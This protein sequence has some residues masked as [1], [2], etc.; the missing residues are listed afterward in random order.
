MFKRFRDRRVSPEIR[1]QNRET[2]L[3]TKDFIYPVFLLE[4]KEREE[5]IPS[6]PGVSRRSLDRLL[7]YLEWPVKLG[8]RSILVFA[9]PDHKGVEQA[10]RSDGLM[11]RSLP[12]IKSHFPQLEVITDV[13]ICSF[14]ENGQ[15]H[16]GDN[17]QTIEILAKIALS[18]LQSGADIVAP[19]DMMDGRVW[20]IHRLLTH[21][22]IK[23]PQI[24]SYAAKYASSFYGPFR[25][26]ADCAPKTGD[27]KSY[28]MDPANSNEAM[29]EIQADLEEG[30]TSIIIKPALSYLDIIFRASKRFDCPI[31][32][33]S[34]SGEY[35]ALR[36][37]V[38]QGMASSDIIEETLLSTKRAG[39]NR[40]ITYFTPLILEKKNGNQLV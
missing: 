28:Q 30:A 27:R 14:T 10:Y 20:A 29:E 2:F 18:Y 26:A 22:G 31:I 12:D 11:Q 4:G 35:A 21:S 40:I 1:M 33:Y 7:K 6:M 16:M 32:A 3:E 5:A 8:L 19:S 39:A 23:Q 9:I 25:D 36:Y 37:L 13:C 38:D 34:V 15:C 24:I 17:D